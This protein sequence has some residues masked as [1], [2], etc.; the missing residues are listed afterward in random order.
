LHVAAL[1]RNNDGPLRF[2][3]P[4]FANVRRDLALAAAGAGA[5]LALALAG[6]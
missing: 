1:A 5:L 2:L 3:E 6:A 4:V